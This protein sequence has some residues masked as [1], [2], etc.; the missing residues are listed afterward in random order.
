[1]AADSLTNDSIWKNLTRDTAEAANGGKLGVRGRKL[2]LQIGAGKCNSALVARRSSG[3]LDA[4]LIWIVR[5]Q[6]LEGPLQRLHPQH[7]LDRLQLFNQLAN[8]VSFRNWRTSPA[9]GGWGPYKFRG[10][11]VVGRSDYTPLRR[12]IIQRE[13]FRG[14]CR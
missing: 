5:R 9:E 7:V 4:V 6:M 1:M 3:P 8:L 10:G 11:I 13:S 12:W 2:P 14:S